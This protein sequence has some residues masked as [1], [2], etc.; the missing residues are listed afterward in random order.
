MSALYTQSS[1]ERT[2]FSDKQITYV[3]REMNKQYTDGTLLWNLRN[4]RKKEK[5]L[6]SS[7]S[8]DLKKYKMTTRENKSIKILGIMPL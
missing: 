8:L 4:R 1:E 3:K 6:R 7:F 2:L 5:T